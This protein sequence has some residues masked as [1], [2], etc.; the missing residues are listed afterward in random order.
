[1]LGYVQK[2]TIQDAIDKVDGKLDGSRAAY[3]LA[4]KGAVWTTAMQDARLGDT[5]V[6]THSRR[7]GLGSIE[8]YHSF[9]LCR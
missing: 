7:N 4:P 8:I 2:G 3:G 5:R 6:S 1:M 9:L